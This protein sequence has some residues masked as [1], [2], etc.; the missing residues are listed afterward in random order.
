MLPEPI[1]ISVCIATYRR[2]GMLADLLESL[3]G[4]QLEAGVNLEI[5][6][7]DN[8][9]DGTAAA[10]VE[11][12]I[13]LD[14]FYAFDYSVQPGRN[15]S[16]VR[17]QTV[18]RANGEFIAFIDDDETAAPDWVSNLLMAL[19]TYQADAAVGPVLPLYPAEIPD[20]MIQGGFFER[21][22]LKTGTRVLRA[23]TGNVLVRKECI[24]NIE[25]GPFRLEYGRTGGEDT[26]LFHRLHKSGCKVVWADNAVVAELVPASRATV[27]YLTRRAF[28]GGQNYASITLPDMNRGRKIPWFITRAAMIVFGSIVLPFFWLTGR[29]RGLKMQQKVAGYFG[30]L[31]FLLPFRMSEY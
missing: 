11:R 20:W 5:V 16:L 27:R 22:R 30:Q 23:G 15:L 26:D 8:D 10:V 25:T 13:N 12:Y 31:S 3:A 18:A 1:L 19:T 21:R 7:V 6:V 24:P 29:I 9:P 17:N 2:Q 28:R 14:R 4:Q